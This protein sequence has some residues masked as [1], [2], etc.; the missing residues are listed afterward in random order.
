MIQAENIS[1][2]YGGHTLLEDAGF[3]LQQGER[4]G[5]IGR[6]GT[7]K[8]TLFRLLSGE[9]TPDKGRILFPRG[10]RIGLLKQQIHFTK[11]TIVEEA[12]LGLRE[13][14][15]EC[16]YKVE[17]LLSGL[18][19][20]EDLF[21]TDPRRLSG[22][23]QLRVQLVKVLVSEPDCLLLDEPTNYL[24]ILSIRFLTRFLRKWEGEMIL[25]SHDLEFL[26]SVTTH[27][28]GVHRHRLEKIR[29]KSTD[30]FTMIAEE[31]EAH[32]RNRQ[33]LDK[34]R[35][36]L[37][38][39]IERFGAKASK[40]TQAQSKVKQLAKIPVLERLKALYQLDFSFREAP[41][42]GKK[43]L[44]ATDLNFSYDKETPLIDQV[45]LTIEK[46]D[47]IAIVGK[48]GN[49]KST[50]L[51]MLAQE[52]D[53]DQGEIE[54]SSNLQTGYFGQTCIER[55]DPKLKIEEEIASANPNLNF[56]NIRAICGLMMFSGDLAK[57]A[58]SVLS[59]GEKSRVLL[60]KIIAKPCNLLLLD[61]PTHHLDVESIEALIDAIEAFEGAVIMVTHSEW[62]LKR[63]PFNKLIVCHKEK[64]QFFLGSYQE[65]L[66]TEG[67]EEEVEE[68]ATKPKA[69]P[70]AKPKATP[71]KGEI[72]RCEE[73]IT[74]LESALGANN[75]QLIAASS[76]GN[77]EKIRSLV[78]AIAQQE[79][80]L[81]ALYQVL[82]N[83]E[84]SH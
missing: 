9:E 15:E 28:M 66:D 65:F 80:E 25:I 47:R 64:Q 44:E 10:Y 68:K 26:D 8:S 11:P 57:K 53:P 12:A 29:G 78:T 74:T 35:A 79:A 42:P 17:A 59:G 40:A 56:G 62:V 71:S 31:E 67:W 38:S 18:G 14:E 43:M 39:F 1:L 20:S 13:G 51:K 21:D 72:K 36:H 84:S 61:E 7:G 22:G 50:L 52:L 63:I 3:T 49:G 34:K 73:K 41:F 54:T 16:L 24:D 48:N 45:S 83:L 27:M 23:Y 77:A 4:C 76:V 19:F 58:I 2:S 70:A 5:L 69:P 55:L 81:K 46:G 30:L 75:E 33:T 82:E 32:E 6:N 37:E 60:G